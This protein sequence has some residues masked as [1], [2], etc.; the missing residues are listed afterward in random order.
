M[1]GQTELF[2][3]L[4]EL[5]RGGRRERIANGTKYQESFTCRMKFS[6][7]RT[8]R[9]ER[10]FGDHTRTGM[11]Y[12][13]KR[14]LRRGEITMVISRSVNFREI[15]ENL[16]EGRE[17]CFP[18]ERCRKWRVLQTWHGLTCRDLNATW[19]RVWNSH[20]VVN[21]WEIFP[22]KKNRRKIGYVWFIR[23]YVFV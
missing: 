17:D 4:P 22:L 8:V 5:T 9:G 7:M 15:G 3:E 12:L 21:L 16:E 13:W 1:A 23:I 2:R 6:L 14:F 20:C 18:V 11:Y 19:A 10:G